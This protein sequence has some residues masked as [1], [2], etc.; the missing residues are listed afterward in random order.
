MV[1]ATSRP[2]RQPV[3]GTDAFSRRIS[4]A[5]LI[6]PPLLA[7]PSRPR[8]S[9]TGRLFDGVFARVGLLKRISGPVAKTSRTI[10]LAAGLNH[11]E[12]SS[13]GISA[14]H[15]LAAQKTMAKPAKL[16]ATPAARAFRI[17]SI[18]VAH[19]FGRHGRQALRCA[20]ARDTM[21]AHPTNTRLP[22]PS[23]GSSC[24]TPPL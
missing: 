10:P 21:P 18:V 1:C 11:G 7:H 6:P 22:A 5:S 2:S 24:R 9:Q 16:V 23:S 12:V 13:R 4:K 19:G 17:V 15:R 20:G 8:A 14:R 3:K